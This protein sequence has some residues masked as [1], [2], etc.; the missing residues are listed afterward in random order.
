LACPI[1]KHHP[2]EARF[3]TWETSQEELKKAV[4]KTGTPSSTFKK[5]YSQ[6][7]KQLQDGTISPTAIRAMEELTNSI[8]SK[9]L[10]ACAI[11]AMNRLELSLDKP[12]EDLIQG[13]AEDI[14]RLHRFLNLLEVDAGLLVCSKCGRWYPVG[15]S[16]ETI[17]ELLPDDLRDKE[18]DVAWLERW[19]E[20]IPPP[21]LEDGKPFNLDD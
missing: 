16:V 5:S 20:L 21:V 19:K 15:S 12:E 18:R 8:D 4:M 14:D 17:P 1:D 13:F 11:E 10:L 9:E 7:A 3:F 6:L 2:L